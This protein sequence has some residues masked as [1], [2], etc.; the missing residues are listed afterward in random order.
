[1]AIGAANIRLGKA[2]EIVTPEKAT[3]APAIQEVFEGLEGVGVGVGVGVG[4]E[5]GGG[6]FW[7]LSPPPHATNKKAVININILVAFIIPFS[8]LRPLEQ[9]FNFNGFIL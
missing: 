7:T 6:S 5:G 9:L 8:P 4:L 3:G 1:M 2:L